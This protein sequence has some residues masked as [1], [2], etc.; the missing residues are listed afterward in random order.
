MQA[1]ENK[2]TKLNTIP[3]NRMVLNKSIKKIETVVSHVVLN[4]RTST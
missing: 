4:F 1:F 2:L 3:P